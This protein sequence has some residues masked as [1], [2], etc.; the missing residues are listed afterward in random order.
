[1]QKG[2]LRVIQGDHI[3]FYCPGCKSLHAINVGPNGWGFSDSSHALA[4]Q[5]VDLVAR[6]EAE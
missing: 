1:M 5:T 2:V 4:G 6:P 3:G